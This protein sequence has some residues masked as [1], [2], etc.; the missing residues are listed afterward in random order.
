MGAPSCMDKGKGNYTKSLLFLECR[1]EKSM[2][3]NPDK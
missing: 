3:V 2:A 1:K